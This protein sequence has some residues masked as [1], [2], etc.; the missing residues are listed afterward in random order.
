ME[1]SEKTALVIVDAQQA[2]YEPDMGALSNPDFEMQILD[3]LTLWRARHWPVFHVKHTSHEPASPYFSLSPSCE[4][5]E[6]TAPVAGEPVVG[7]EYAS[8]FLNSALGSMLRM[9][10]CEQ[11]VICGAHTHKAVDATV[12][13]ASGLKFETYV[14]SDACAAADQ[15]DLSGRLWNGE[16]V[17]LLAL[18]VLNEDY[19]KVIS[20]Q[21]IFSSI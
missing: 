18:G 4:F 20:M 6:K 19:A 12:R 8:A 9:D 5:I 15:T 21:D 16:D 7:K 2:L 3:L 11:L 17:H 13:H 14:V 1:L 10:G